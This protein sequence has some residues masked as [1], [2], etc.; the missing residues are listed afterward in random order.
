MQ[1]LF[2]EYLCTSS[3]RYTYPINFCPFVPESP[4]DFSLY[5]IP[6]SACYTLKMHY[7]ELIPAKPKP[8]VLVLSCITSATTYLHI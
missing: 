6:R 5:S 2:S 1:Y 3:I 7:I 4:T 8:H